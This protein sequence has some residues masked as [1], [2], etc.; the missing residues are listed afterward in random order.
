MALTVLNSGLPNGLPNSLPSSLPMRILTGQERAA[1]IMMAMGTEAAQKVVKHLDPAQIRMITKAGTHLGSISHTQINDL[2][3]EFVESFTEGS[4]VIGGASEIQKL[5]SHILPKEQLDAIMEEFHGANS[6]SIWERIS[7]VLDSTVAAYLNKEHPQTAAVIL[8]KINPN[9]AARVLEQMPADMRNTVTNRMLTL[10]PLTEHMLKNVEA[11][12]QENFASNFSRDASSDTH[13][14][15][16]KIINKMERETQEA[17]LAEIGASRPKSVEI[18]KSM[19]FTFD[20]IIKLN[21]SDRSVLFDLIQPDT[22]AVALNGTDAV[23]KE[24]ILS[25]MSVRTRR[26]IE[27]II[28]SSPTAAQKDVSEARRLVTDTVLD[29]AARNKITLPGGSDEPSYL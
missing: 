29:L 19:L 7:G 17:V 21:A 11:A 8:S 22:I 25:S 24:T 26:I 3:D 4:D 1:A 16:A 10:K 13:S 12:L 27:N 28:E 15:M 23:L 6:S 2:V 18:L 20:D 14:R 9:T 5:L